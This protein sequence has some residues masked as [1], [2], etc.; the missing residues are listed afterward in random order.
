[1]TVTSKLT[2]PLTIGCK[3]SGSFKDTE[4]LLTPGANTI[5]GAAW[6]Q[7]AGRPGVAARVERGELVPEG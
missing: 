4:I 7:V 5:H 3:P 1:M 6:K 2:Y